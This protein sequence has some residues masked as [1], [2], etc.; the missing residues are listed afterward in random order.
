[1]F[2]V[3]NSTFNTQHSTF[4]VDDL[5]EAVRKAKSITKPTKICLLSPAAA[6]YDMFKNFEHRGDAF[7][8]FVKEF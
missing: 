6:S 5:K 2:Q 1:V 8:Q 3:S 7:I 4:L